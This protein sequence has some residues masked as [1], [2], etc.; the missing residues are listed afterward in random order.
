MTDRHIN[1]YSSSERR[2]IMA[3]KLFDIVSSHGGWYDQNQYVNKRQPITFRCAANHEWTAGAQVVLSGSWCRQ[4]WEAEKA[5][6]HLILKDG[7]QKAASLAQSRGGKCLS[8]EYVATPRKL[9]WQCENGHQWLATFSDVRKGSWCPVCG[10]GVRERL[11]RHYFQTLTQLEFP[12]ARPNWLINTRGN[13]MELDG[14]CAEIKLAFEHQG[15]QHYQ[16]VEHFN[17]RN[18]TLFQRKDDDNTKRA[19]C[20]RNNITLIEIPYHIPDKELPTW[21]YQEIKATRP[22]VA[23]PI[24]PSAIDT[25]YVASDELKKLKTTALARGGLC[26]TEVYL[27]ALSK[28]LFRCSCGHTWEATASSINRGGW[29]PACKPIRIGNSNRKHSIESMTLLANSKGGEFLSIEF[30]SVNDRYQWKCS[31]GHEWTA[32]P[33]DI[34]GGTWCPQCSRN[35]QKGSIEEFKELA[36]SRGGKCLSDTYGGSQVKLQWECAE[37]HVWL[38]TPGNVK[39]R[40]S[41]CPVC[42]RR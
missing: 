22:D 12:K 11:C 31:E 26:L 6:K 8:T 24:D 25:K 17:R 15:E 41:W 40:R 14:F 33:A 10:S 19:L 29:C 35:N 4:C 9:N 23:L 5:G 37:G 28:H 32:A 2:A 3:K 27:G 21:I 38:A 13:R 36:R 20:K 16:E 7:L 30:R 39:N 1:S 42:R 34:I 18:E